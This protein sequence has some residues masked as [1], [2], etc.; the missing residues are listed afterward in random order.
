[1][2][3]TDTMVTSTGLT[4]FVLIA[5]IIVSRNLDPLHPTG[6]QNAIEL[7]VGKLYDF[8]TGVMGEY[9]CKKYFPL[10][11]ALFI[12]ILICNY[13]G[14]LPL[15]GMVPG[16]A[17]PT[18]VINFPAGFAIIVFFALQIISVKE[19][20]QRAFKRFFEPVAFVFPLLIIDEFVKPMSLCLRLYGNTSGDERV[21][22]VFRELCPLA[23][24]VV[25]Q[26]L[27]ILLAL[28]QALV[29]SLL[30][31]IYIS[32][33]CESGGEDHLPEPEEAGEN[34]TAVKAAQLEV[35]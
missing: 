15:A 30:T 12:Y 24:P 31:A 8:F 2:G 27:I 22:E 17:A 7:G 16:F 20:K 11:G 18:S 25:A 21:V 33:V 19:H 23:L 35:A 32:E 14:L 26:F 3:I 34:D 4:L 13:S 6:V 1:M 10:V 29:F 5:S 28:I 9:A